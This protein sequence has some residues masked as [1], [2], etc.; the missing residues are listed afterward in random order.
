MLGSALGMFQLMP[1]FKPAAGKWYWAQSMSLKMTVASGGENVCSLNLTECTILN[2]VTPIRKREPPCCL[3]L[4]AVK[5]LN[6]RL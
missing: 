3:D 6:Q 2:S 4:S 5:F 1:L